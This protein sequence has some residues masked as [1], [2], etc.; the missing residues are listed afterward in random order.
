MKHDHP[1]LAGFGAHQRMVPLVAAL[2]TLIVP[3]V[4]GSPTALAESRGYVISWFSVAT[5]NPDFAINCPQTIKE[6]IS[7]IGKRR[8]TPAFVDGKEVAA[9]DYPD[10]L[11]KDP[12]L[13]TVVGK[14]AYGFD[15]GGPEAG[16]FTDPETHEKVDNQ[17]W[18]AIGCTANFQFTPP[19]MPYLEG[20]AWNSGYA[21]DAPAWALRISGADLSKDGP[22]TVTLDRTLS[23]LERDALGGIRS[24]VT[25]VLDPSP[26]SHN[27]LTGEIQ[28]GVLWIKSGSLWLEGSLPFYSQVDLVNTHMRLRSEA[29]GKL[30]GYWGGYT[31]W[32]IWA[33]MYTSRCVVADCVGM[34]RALEKLADYDPDPATGKNRKISLTYRTEAVPAFLSSEDG[35]ILATASGD[36]LGGQVHPTVA[37]TTPSPSIDNAH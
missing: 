32:H 10:A 19:T 6:Q 23:H 36:A 5:N 17:L 8:E 29:A 35:K 1:V 12:D 18:R 33:Y 37:S 15:L 21:D 28:D 4:F 20:Q 7:R 27:V 22:V 24:D 16:K 9:L 31:D 2:V 34:Y 13:E 26:R 11:Q 3:L 30:V 14:Y 25:Y